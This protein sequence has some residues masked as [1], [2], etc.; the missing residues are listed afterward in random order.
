MKK[1]FVKMLSTVVSMVDVTITKNEGS[2]NIKVYF[3]NTCV[4]DKTIPIV[5]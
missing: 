3:L 4:V 5:V 2:V 1:W